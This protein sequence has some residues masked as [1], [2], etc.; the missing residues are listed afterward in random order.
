MR[1]RLF[2]CAAVVAQIAAGNPATQKPADELRPVTVVVLDEA[3]GKPIESFT[4]QA[5]YDAPG[6]AEAK[7][8]DKW[9][10][11]T[12]PSGTFAHPAPPSCRLSV[13]AKAP[14][15]VDEYP[16]VREFVIKAQD[17]PRRVEVRLRRGI[18][19][20]GVVRDSRTRGPI[21]GAS[22]APVYQGSPGTYPDEEREV[23]ADAD[24]RFEL[25]GVDPK[26]G[27]WASHPDYVRFPPSPAGDPTGPDS[28]VFLTQGPTITARVL[29]PDGEPLEGVTAKD[30]SKEWT[31][32]GKDGVLVL[33][34]AELILGLK[35]FKEGFIT[36]EVEREEILRDL[37]KPEGLVVRLERTIP[38][39]G[40][41]LS[42]DGQPIATF[43]VAAGPGKLPSER[44][45]FGKDVQEAEGRF[46]LGLAQEGTT[47]V[48]VSADGF[49]AWEGWIDLKR[50]G[51]PM[52]IRL[53]PGV[54]LS[55]SI[56]PVTM[57]R[58]FTKATL[59]PRRDKSAIGGMP[60]DPPAEILPIRTAKIAADGTIKIEHV[61]PDRYRLAIQGEGRSGIEQTLDDFRLAVEGTDS[62]DIILAVDVPEG[63][64][65][66]GAI[67]VAAPASTG[68]VVGRVWH[69]E[70]EKK[71][72]WSFAEGHVGGVPFRADE[73][74]RFAAEGVPVGLRTLSIP[75]QV[76]DVI[77]AH[78]WS[79]LVVEGKTTV[80]GAFEPD[81]HRTFTL[82]VAIGDGSKLHHDSGT[83]LGAARKVDNVT[84]RSEL[85]SIPGE[86]D[87][88]PKPQF[89][90]VDLAP[91]SKEPLAFASPEWEE[92]DAKRKIN[93]PDVG[94]GLYRL[95]I[96]DWLGQ[97][98]W[99]GAP[100]YEGDVAVPPGGDGEVKIPL[101]AGC[102]TGK[103][104]A[105]RTELQPPDA[106]IDLRPVEVF[107]VAMGRNLPPRTARCDDD[108]NFCVRYLTPGLYSLFIHDPRAGSCVVE[109]VEVNSAA[110]DVG[111]RV[112]SAKANADCSI[113][114]A[115][116]SPV[117]DELV[118]TDPSGVTIRHELEVYSS[119][120]AAE[121]RGL[122]PGR[123]TFTARRGGEV[124]ATSEADVPETGTIA[125][126]LTVGGGT[127]P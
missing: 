4:Y 90:R 3:T 9:T 57:S 52:D 71:G 46:S 104:P 47:W 41:V 67:P 91:V 24:G 121:F 79:V 92:L 31:A 100:L 51:E 6:G 59:F 76:Y 17:A 62:P 119:F 14:D 108:G 2:A 106:A 105:L 66:I 63:G 20:K 84:K 103:G 55:A 11:V 1:I 30:L 95:R 127:K 36:R 115:K 18:T 124:L 34:N 43:R 72:V 87:T 7:T 42:P 37:K 81:A 50:G 126:T 117:P 85:F 60:S 38:L 64:I 40:R 83:G 116:A 39:R 98:G 120:D 33:R 96:Y 65:D 80:V 49:A 94:P 44:N 89:L 82:A 28:D 88:S 93:L 107:A 99:D 8:D 69:S 19:V 122:W 102:I 35:F 109:G 48:G 110:V 112:V 22:V 45:S 70:N 12:S 16:S 25:R 77:S 101:G 27:V 58:K 68:R 54:T 78:T 21:A 75:F 61:R 56:G 23:K 29:G 10:A 118:A 114:F 74:G 113:R 26:L 111:E 86:K 5:W 32:S 97:R 73:E 125:V 123:W 53:S 13:V 15:Y